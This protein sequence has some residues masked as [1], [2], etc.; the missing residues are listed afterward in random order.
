MKALAFKDICAGKLKDI[1]SYVSKEHEEQVKPNR[2]ISLSLI[3]VVIAFGQWNF[4]FVVISGISKLIEDRNFD[5][6]VHLKAQFDVKLADHLQH[7]KKM[8][9]IPAQKYRMS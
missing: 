4:L 3:D 5:F 2:T 1:Q 7:C 6:F 8:L 9:L